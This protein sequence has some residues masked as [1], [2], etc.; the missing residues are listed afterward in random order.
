VAEDNP[1]VIFPVFTNGILIDDKIVSLFK[2]HR[3]VIP[4]LS[5]E[6]GDILTDQRRG[7]GVYERA[8]QKMKSLKKNSIFFGV[9]FTVMKQ[10]LSEVISNEIVSICWRRC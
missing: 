7:K 2:K 6:G 8:H 5:I 4:V 10:N 1:S 9:S 3:N